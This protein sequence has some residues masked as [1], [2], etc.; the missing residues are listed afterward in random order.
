M[1]DL[2]HHCP[3][4]NNCVAHGNRRAFTAFTMA[5]SAG[6]LLHS[7][8]AVWVEHA[9]LCPAKDSG[10]TGSIYYSVVS[11]CFPVAVKFSCWLLAFSYDLLCPFAHKFPF[12]LSSY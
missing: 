2:D 3:F 9:V 11:C 5:A 7:V 8:L 10:S 12:L 4:V 1:V 6:C